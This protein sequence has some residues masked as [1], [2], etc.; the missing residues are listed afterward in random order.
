MYDLGKKFNIQMM[1]K[2]ANESISRIYGFIL[3]RKSDA[4][5]REVIQDRTFWNSLNDISGANWPIFITDPL[6]NCN[7]VDLLS[8]KE[9]FQSNGDRTVSEYNIS[10]LKAFDINSSE[11]LPLFI[12][13]I[14]DDNDNIIRE[15]WEIEG[16]N[17]NEV[18]T[19][20][21]EI[22]QTISKTEQYILNDYKPE[23]GVYRQVSAGIR[24]LRLKKRTKKVLKTIQIITN[25]INLLQL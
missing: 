22:V 24:S 17:K 16:N 9:D 14:W 1:H 18:Y 6:T 19:N 12:T 7:N 5:V 15:L 23:R 25:F 4:F 21:K 10:I 13:F 8:M 11:K 2:A 3:Y 20:I